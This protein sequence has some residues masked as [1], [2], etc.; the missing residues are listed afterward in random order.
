MTRTV[1]NAAASLAV[2]DCAS[3]VRTSLSSSSTFPRT[4]RRSAI[5]GR[6]S[7]AWPARRSSRP[8]RQAGQSRAASPGRGSLRMSW[9]R[10]IATTFPCTGRAVSMLATA[11]SS[12][13]PRWSDGSTKATNCS[14]RWWP[15]SG[16]TRWRERRCMPTTRRWAS[17]T[18]GAG[19]PRQDGCGST[20]E[21]IARPRA[22]MHRL[23]GSNTRL[24][25][26]AS[27]RRRTSR[28][29]PAFCRPTPTEVGA[30]C[31]AVAASRKLLAGLTRDDHGGI[32]T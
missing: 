11:C 13:A 3:S 9:S 1:S 21:T 22:R 32:C 23:S 26:R 14:T 18:R 4:S 15:H 27:I 29:S 31:T 2:A 25:A 8:P 19:A 7:R 12:I 30:S 24:I 28:T 5:S 16:A 20:C 17:S 10:S 6:S